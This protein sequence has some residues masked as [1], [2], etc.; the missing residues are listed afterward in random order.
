MRLHSHTVNLYSYF[1]PSSFIY[2]LVLIPLTLSLVLSLRD[3]RDRLYLTSN[4]NHSCP[5]NSK[6]MGAMATLITFKDEGGYDC[7]HLKWLSFG[8]RYK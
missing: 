6:T 8:S 2:L 7:L 3:N 5:F 1:L 4:D